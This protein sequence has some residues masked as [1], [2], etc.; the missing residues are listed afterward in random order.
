MPSKSHATQIQL[1]VISRESA[2][3]AHPTPLLFVHRA[4][5]RA[6]CWNEHFLPCFAAHSY[7]SYA[8]S[9][10]GHGT[11]ASPKRFRTARVR[12]YVEDV[13]QVAGQLDR[14]PVLIGHSMGELVVQKYLE[15]HEAPAACQWPACRRAVFFARP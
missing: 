8:L 3:D 12:D 9:L 15:T 7:R 4:W 14:P 11:S 10:R 1:E 2:G 5:H 13:A 6:W